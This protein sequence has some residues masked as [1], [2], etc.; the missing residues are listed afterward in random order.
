MV[1]I[2]QEFNPDLILVSAGF[3]A[4]EGHPPTLGGYSVTPTCKPK[5]QSP[6]S[7]LLQLFG[8]WLLGRQC[9]QLEYSISGLNEALDGMAIRYFMIYEIPYG[10]TVF[11]MI[12]KYRMAIRYFI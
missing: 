5:L 7:L 6:A 8:C 12:M 4:T 2:A 10:H 9:S 11:H 3:N 1:P